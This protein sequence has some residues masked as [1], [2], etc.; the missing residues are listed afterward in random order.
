ME[1][2]NILIYARRSSEKNK[3]TSIS[4]EKQISE[5]KAACKRR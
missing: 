3:M 1:A 4:I 2:K 5:V